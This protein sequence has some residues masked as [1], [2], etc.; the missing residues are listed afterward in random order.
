MQKRASGSVHSFAVSCEKMRSQSRLPICTKKSTLYTLSYAKHSKVH[1]ILP[2]RFAR[3]AGRRS[4][5]LHGIQR[6]QS[7]ECRPPPITERRNGQKACRLCAHFLIRVNL[8]AH[9]S[10]DAEPSRIGAANILM[11]RNASERSLAR[12]CASAAGCRRM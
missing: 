9:P 11:L 6:I 4:S 5:Q 8:A 10:I 2:C 3:P 7:S 12:E 1:G